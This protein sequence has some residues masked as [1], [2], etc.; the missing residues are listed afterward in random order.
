VFANKEL[1]QEVTCVAN[2]S[3]T[4]ADSNVIKIPQGRGWA[5]LFAS[6]DS[7]LLMCAI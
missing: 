3:Q 2:C 4:D 7:F 1:M 5:T 6:S